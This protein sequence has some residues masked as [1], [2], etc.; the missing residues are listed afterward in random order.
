MA[1][2]ITKKRLSRAPDQPKLFDA[3]LYLP[4]GLR[5]QPDFISA[6]EESAL[7][8]IFQSLALRPARFRE[9]TA[10]RNIKMFG[11]GFSRAR[12]LFLPGPPLPDFLLPLRDR[13]GAWL[14]IDPARIVHALI[15]EYRPGT[16]IGWHR[17]RERFAHVI[18]ISLGGWCTMRFRRLERGRPTDEIL[19]LELEP[20]S[21]YVME[22]DMRWKWQHGIPPVKSHRY[23]ITFRTLPEEATI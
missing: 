16:P 21:A 10:R 17:D 18:G 19:P 22:G 1:V 11:W 8:D 2:N 5:Y 9:Y 4:S 14:G 15:T 6:E 13:I 7:L 3:P 12:D 20:R 23:S